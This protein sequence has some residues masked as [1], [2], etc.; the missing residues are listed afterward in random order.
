YLTGRLA[1]HINS[2]LSFENGELYVDD[3]LQALPGPGGTSFINDLAQAYISLT[4]VPEVTLVAGKRRLSWGAGYAFFPG[5]LIDPPVNPGNRSEGF[6]GFTATVSPSASF[7]L[8]GAVRLD[9]AFPSLAS[10][11]GF[12]AS[13]SDGG[14]SSLPFLASYLPAT[15]TNPWAAVR[16]ALYADLLLGN[17][18]TYAA[19]TYQ[20]DRLLR[21][22]A[23]F[24]VD[25]GGVIANGEVAVELENSSLY[26]TAAG[27]YEVPAPGKPFPVAT[28][29]LQRTASN[30]VASYG[31]T[32]EYLYDGTGYDQTQAGRFYDKLATILA[33][34]SPDSSVAAATLAGGSAGSAWLAGSG[35]LPGFGRHYAALSVSASVTHV[36]SGTVA[37]IVNIQDGSFAV[38]P[39]LRLTH[40]SGIDIFARAVLA[41]G[42]NS[43]TEF[44]LESTPVTVTAGTIV[45]F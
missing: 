5:D 21:P 45:H 40:F 35:V 16:Y 10:V 23:G 6:Y 8:T 11:G 42:W 18:D 30:D 17:L 14:L 38:Q 41:W 19:V 26:P 13:G 44:G 20:W 4:P 34:A 31:V 9:T 24:S 33:S 37:A 12:V 27:T 2:R 3:S 7:T 22:A 1:L 28:V 32:V 39:E 25:L 36:I 29:G 43:R 15:P